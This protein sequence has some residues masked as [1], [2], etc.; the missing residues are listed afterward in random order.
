MNIRARFCR[1]VGCLSV[2]LGKACGSFYL[3]AI[4]LSVYEVFTRYL[5]D[6][7]TVWTTE[8]VMACCATAWMVSAGAITQQ[9]R[10]ITVTSMELLVGAAAWLVLRRIALALSLLA[11]A[12]LTW[13]MSGPALRAAV[14]LERSGSAFNPPLPSYLKV[15]LALACLVFA[16]QLFAKLI[17]PRSGHPLGRTDARQPS[18]EQTRD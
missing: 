18:R 16:L 4:G 13:A 15:M 8:A 2:L 1:A 5:L 10:H 14:Q 11:V 12:G 17:A 9:N 7:P 6:A 3:T